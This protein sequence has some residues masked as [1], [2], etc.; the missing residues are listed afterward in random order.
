MHREHRH[1]DRGFTLLELMIVVAIAGILAATAVPSMM[2]YIAKAKS[3]EAMMHI[4]KMYNGARIYW[5]EPHGAAGSIQPLPAQFP[6][7]HAATPALS[8]CASG[9]ARCLPVAAE[10]ADPT[11]LG[12]GFSMDDPYY[13]QYEFLSSAS[14]F[15][16]RAIGNLDC[17]ASFSTFSMIGRVDANGVFGLAAMNRTNELE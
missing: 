4:E 16:A 6:D 10:W 13:Y 7:A 11:W 5:L 15:T 8:C 1:V 12:L 3:T 9:G 14:E 2:H 17:D